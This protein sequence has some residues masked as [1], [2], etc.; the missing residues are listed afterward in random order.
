MTIKQ[1]LRSYYYNKKFKGKFIMKTEKDYYIYILQNGR[2]IK[3]YDN[4]A[5]DLGQFID[6]YL[7]FYKPEKNNVIID[8]GAYVGAFSIYCS[9]LIGNK[10]LIIAI[11]P[12]INNYKNLIKNL[13]LNNI[14]NVKVIKKALYSERNKNLLMSDNKACSTLKYQIL[15]GEI[16][17][18]KS[19]TIDN[20][21]KN[22]NI[23]KVDFIKIDVVGS[24][25]EVLKGAKETL[26]N[27]PK[28]SVA[29]YP[30]RHINYFN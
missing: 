26:K 11:E 30:D 22:L 25:K 16:F 28:M 21:L 12:N 20:I 7:K 13:E 8:A 9:E 4:I 15:E 18:I 6:E 27:K 2:I 3:S 17:K 23:E 19:E 24:E 10:G 5:G 14:R 29:E 1:K